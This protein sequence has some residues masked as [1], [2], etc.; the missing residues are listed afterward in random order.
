MELETALYLDQI[1][2]W[3]QSGQRIMASYD[4]N[5]IVVYQAYKPTIAEAIL[6][7]QNFHDP[8]CVAAGFSLTRM[9]WIKTNFLWMMYRSGWARKSNQERILAIRLTRK[10]FEEILENA[11]KI[12]A[13]HRI[14]DKNDE[15]L[16]RA[17][18]NP[19]RKVVLQWDP[20]H[21]PD[22]EKIVARRAVQL[23]LSNDILMKFST[24]Y[25]VNVTDVTEFVHEQYERCLIKGKPFRDV[26]R[27][28]IPLEREFVPSQ[29]DICK[30][31]FLTI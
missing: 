31:I 1:K 30:H 29:V 6:K 24:E 23:G 22:G 21:M 19:I 10:G 16:W 5:T 26:S 14:K 28:E 8:I 9:T 25:I 2:T 27:L 11:L 12:N 20:D 7:A 4:Q 13:S 17:P 15:D 18:T 3:P